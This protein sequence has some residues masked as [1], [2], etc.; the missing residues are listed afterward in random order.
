LRAGHAD[1][2]G[3]L[4]RA[5]PQQAGDVTEQKGHFALRASGGH[6]VPQY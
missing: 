1:G 6:V 4:I 3:A 2:G 5:C